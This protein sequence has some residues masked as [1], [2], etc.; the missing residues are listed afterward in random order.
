[1]N[2][3]PSYCHTRRYTSCKQKRTKLKAATFG[4]ENEF[5]SGSP[6]LLLFAGREIIAVLLFPVFGMSWIPPVRFGGL[7]R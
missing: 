1:M 3:W 4:D 7:L 2:S 6:G 5:A